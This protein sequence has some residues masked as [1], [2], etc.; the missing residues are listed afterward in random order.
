MTEQM[1][2]AAVGQKIL[3]ALIDRVQ[4][5]YLSVRRWWERGMIA[6]RY[7]EVLTRDDPLGCNV[8]QR[9]GC[10]TSVHDGP[11]VLE[12]GHVRIRRRTQGSKVALHASRLHC[13]SKASCNV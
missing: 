9:N 11:K 12:H 8:C 13:A 7:R 1:R 3:Q 5:G 10:A 6:E 2:K 4:G